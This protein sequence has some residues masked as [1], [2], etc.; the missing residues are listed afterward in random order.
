MSCARLVLLLLLIVDDFSVLFCLFGRPLSLFFSNAAAPKPPHPDAR[1]IQ[2]KV[3]IVTGSN[4]GVGKTIAM[5]LARRGAV[6]TMACRSASR[7]E[8]ARQQILDELKA[9]C[10]VSIKDIESRLHVA[11][12]D[13]SSLDSVREFA[14][15]FIAASDNGDRK[16][17][18]LYLNAGIGGVTTKE[19]ILTQDGFERMYQTN[20]L[21]HFL[22][23]YLLR[24]ALAPDARIIS[25]SS[26]FV[27]L[28]LVYSDFSTTQVKGRLDPGFHFAIP[29]FNALSDITA[30]DMSAYAHTKAMQLFMTRA[31]N[32]RALPQKSKRIALAFHPGF[33]STS[34]FRVANDLRTFNGLQV[35]AHLQRVIGLR[36][37]ESARTPIFL[38]TA[39]TAALGK[40]ERLS[41][42][43]ERS[44]AYATPVD[45]MDTK[46][47][48]AR[49]CA[50]L[51]IPTD[52]SI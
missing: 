50:D 40:R 43:W 9:D 52:W 21:G 30:L 24:D 14:K 8:K 17:D 10:S 22:L 36:P 4:S 6:V 15:D 47:F 25:T 23:L 19:Q 42:L 13:S 51:E 7:A 48:W 38:G 11:S 41:Q 3:A 1:D 35:A 34:V 5:E 27:L 18:L 28:G 32:K 2:G 12:F 31:L 16:V 45:V 49:W 39:T 29:P 26:L 37:D 33:V 46:R 20:F 44:M